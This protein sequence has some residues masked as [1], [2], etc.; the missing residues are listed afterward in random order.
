MNTVRLFLVL[1]LAT[2]LNAFMINSKADESSTLQLCHSS[3]VVG[4]WEM[5]GQI[6]AKSY[7]ASP[8]YAEAIRTKPVFFP[9]QYLVFYKNGFV[10]DFEFQDFDARSDAER[11][12]H[13]SELR[14]TVARK[15][16]APPTQ[17][18]R[19]ADDG[20]MLWYDA[21]GRIVSRVLCNKVTA[22]LS[23]DIHSGDMLIGVLQPVGPSS[24]KIIDVQVFRRLSAK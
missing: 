17:T 9:D 1:I 21:S 13:V 4:E 5:S 12:Q 2:P 22:D 20:R 23:Q 6:F 11:A 3:D 24:E 15:V 18:Y 10:H 16:K 19:I 7:Q 8:G 14:D